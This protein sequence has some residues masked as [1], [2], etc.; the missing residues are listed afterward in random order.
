MRDLQ[1]AVRV[2]SKICGLDLWLY[3]SLLNSDRLRHN[4]YSKFNQG[5]P[6]NEVETHNQ[7]RRTRVHH[8]PELKNSC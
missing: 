4:V 5:R 7:G 8:I 1:R 3:I 6:F 2:Y